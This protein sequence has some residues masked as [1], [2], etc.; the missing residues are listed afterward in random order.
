[1]NS[2]MKLFTTLDVS[3]F[4]PYQVEGVI[5]LNEKDEKV[6]NIQFLI[7]SHKFETERHQRI[8]RGRY[9]QVRL[10]HVIN[11]GNMIKSR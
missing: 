6:L 7:T 2:Y 3:V 9:M 10:K 8:Q 11:R 4:R 5:P 1:M